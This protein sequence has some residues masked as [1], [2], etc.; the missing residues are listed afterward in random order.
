[1][2]ELA[3]GSVNSPWV[4]IAVGGQIGLGERSFAVAGSVRPLGDPS[5]D[6][7]F[8]LSGTFDDPLLQ[9]DAGSLI[10]RAGAGAPVPFQAPLP[11]AVEAYAPR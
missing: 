11:L 5:R 10:R 2:V 8:E 3:E 7:P 6:W 4:R 9:P 1:M